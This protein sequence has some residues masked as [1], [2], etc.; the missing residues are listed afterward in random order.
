[1]NRQPPLC[2]YW[3]CF[4]A[5]VLS[6]SAFSE[7]Q[8][9]QNVEVPAPES[10][11][12]RQPVH[13]YFT[14]IDPDGSGVQRFVQRVNPFVSYTH[15]GT[16]FGFIGSNP[17]EIGWQVGRVMVSMGPGQ[18][19]GMWHSLVGMG[20]D[21]GQSMDFNAIY[22]AF[23]A[24][25]YQPKIVA[26]E[27]RAKGKGKFKLE[28]KSATQ[29]LLWSKQLTLD[30]P[31]MWTFSEPL[32]IETVQQAKFINWIA[33][34]NTQ[35]E[36]DSLAFIVQTPDIPYDE[37]VFLASYAKLARCYSPATGLVRD[38][39]HIRDGHFDNVPASG[40][41]VL[42][43]ALASKMGMVGED[44]ARG[45][46]HRIHENVT[47]LENVGGWL[48]HFVKIREDGRYGIVMGTEF[49]T[50]DTSIYYHSM[51]L[52]AE[53]LG[54]AD[55]L[56]KISGQMKALSLDKLVNPEGYLGH[57]FRSDELRPLVSYWK[58]WGGETALVLAL[59]KLTNN[60]VPP[61]MADNGR[62][63]EGIG[64]IPELQSLFYPDFD[65][66]KK[67]AVSRQD[68]LSI[69]QDMLSRQKAYFPKTWPDSRAAKLGFYSLSAGEARF[70]VGYMVSGVDLPQQSYLHPHYVL[71]SACVDPDPGNVYDLL[72]RM[73]GEQ[74]FPPWGL[75]E[76]FS[77]DVTEYLPMQG[78]L[79]AG[80]ETIG[81][82]HL[83]AKHRSES[84]YVYV[85]SMNNRDLRAAVSIFYPPTPT[86]F[87][88]GKS[89][90]PLQA[91]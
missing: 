24:Q 61:R 75:V 26:V 31:D 60:P 7:V 52:A 86:S 29:E 37:Y 36:L 19:A 67:D 59:A 41:F 65:S 50:V 90:N 3:N 62:V 33:E 8:A 63:H 88:E 49:S 11:R 14:V 91:R 77:K 39:A 23:I 10:K 35:A 9:Q 82:Y 78:A 48:P 55:M 38:R 76:H 68:W 58:D 17:D 4:L 51:L 85:A 71:L 69:R 72:R 34:E 74:L 57:G 80:F 79:N 44:F 89:S 70:G 13:E 5:V 18:W 87:V 81:A 30:T 40:F 64:F 25:K 6:V 54:D 73:E 43:T 84:N 12:V 1:M 21:V 27:F 42:S 83:L 46:L 28:I 16:D 22:P 66:S 32:D 47:A 20:R 2:R 45:V 15:L 56:S 53:I